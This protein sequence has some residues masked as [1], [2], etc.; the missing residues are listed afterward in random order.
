MKSESSIPKESAVL[1]K[2]LTGNVR[3]AR[4]R[5][6]NLIG[7]FGIQQLK[8][9]QLSLRGSVFGPAGNARNRASP[10]TRSRRI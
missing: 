2:L 8:A 7:K 1:H 6:K 5:W 10:T 3:L 9:R 4:L